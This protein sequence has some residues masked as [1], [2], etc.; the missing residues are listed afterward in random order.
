MVQRDSIRHP[1]SHIET[2]SEPDQHF[3]CPTLVH[4]THVVR[5]HAG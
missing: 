3:N 1:G 4:K 5:V 2:V